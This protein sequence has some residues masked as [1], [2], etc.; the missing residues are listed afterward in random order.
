MN[1]PQHTPR[2]AFVMERIVEAENLRRRLA[3]LEDEVADAYQA[4]TP[5]ERVAVCRQLGLSQASK[6]IEA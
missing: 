3:E 5:E 4:C 6:G 2:T 1:L